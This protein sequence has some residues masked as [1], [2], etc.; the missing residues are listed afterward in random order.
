[1]KIVIKPEK[2]FSKPHIVYSIYCHIFNDNFKFWLSP[3]NLY[4]NKKEKDL[5]IIGNLDISTYLN[6]GTFKSYINWQY[7]I[8]ICKKYIVLSFKNDGREKYK[9]IW[10]SKDKI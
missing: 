9:T 2:Y 4:I 1:M 6:D 8:S 7:C 3:F 10:L 5:D